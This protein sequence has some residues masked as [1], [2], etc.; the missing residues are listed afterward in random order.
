MDAKRIGDIVQKTVG[1]GVIAAG[2]IWGVF[3]LVAD[4][5]GWL[6]SGVWNESIMSVAEMVRWTDPKDWIGVWKILNWLPAPIVVVL[7]G[8]GILF[9]QDESD[10]DEQ[11]RESE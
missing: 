6:R 11:N 7:I 8:V 1:F 5:F 3:D 10:Q 4:V 9:Y 2:V